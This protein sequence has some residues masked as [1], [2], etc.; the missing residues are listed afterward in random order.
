MVLLPKENRLLM[1]NLVDDGGGRVQVAQA[2]S[3]GSFVVSP[4]FRAAHKGH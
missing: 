1:V 4:D 2:V 3:E